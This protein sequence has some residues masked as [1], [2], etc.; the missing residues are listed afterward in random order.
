MRKICKTQK[1]NTENSKKS[2]NLNKSTQKQSQGA[3]A[4]NQY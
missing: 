1:K 3:K 4:E 2:H